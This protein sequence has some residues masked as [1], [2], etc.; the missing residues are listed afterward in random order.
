MISTKKHFEEFKNE[1]EEKAVKT[2]NG[3]EDAA[4][5]FAKE[6]NVSIKEAKNR[7]EN[8]TNADWIVCP[9]GKVYVMY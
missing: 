6:Y 7:I 9:N 8:D 5:Y 2:F 3:L 1:F 4:N